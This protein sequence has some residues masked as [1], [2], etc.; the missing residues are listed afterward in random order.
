MESSRLFVALPVPDAVQARL[1]TLQTDLR[2]RLPSRAASWTRAEN[3][4]LTLRFLGSVANESIAALKLALHAV[5]AGTKPMRLAAQGVGCFPDLR[6]P[7]ILWSG[8]KGDAGQLEKLQRSVVEAAIP[9]AQT[10]AERNFTGHVA[11]ARFRRLRPR[12]VERLKTFLSEVARQRL[13]SWQ[14]DEF[15]L[16]RSELAPGGSRYTTL[17]KFA[18]RGGISDA[19]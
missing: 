5:S 9:F 11:L 7:A 3:L 14:A 18:F 15:L 2:P 13:G 8:V 4:H 19:T 17:A 12:D 10:P 1:A 6:R 16:I